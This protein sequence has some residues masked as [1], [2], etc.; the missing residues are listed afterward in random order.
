[1]KTLIA[2]LLTV[3]SLQASAAQILGGSYDSTTDN[4]VLDVVYQGGCKEHVFKV[5][6]EMCNR[7]V[8]ASCQAQLVDHTED[9][10]CRGIVHKTIQIPADGVVGSYAIDKMWIQGDGESSSLIDFM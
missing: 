9:D 5:R 2:T 6:V 8:P 3:C 10:V 1:M 4:I 7:V